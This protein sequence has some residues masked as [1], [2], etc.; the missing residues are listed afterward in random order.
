MPMLSLM[1]FFFFL[2]LQYFSIWRTNYEYIN[3]RNMQFMQHRAWEEGRNSPFFSP[4]ENKEEF[5]TNVDC[6]IT[7]RIIS[8]L[9]L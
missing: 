6:H 2:I 5:K 4:S 1:G 9:N 7:G 8:P 3:V